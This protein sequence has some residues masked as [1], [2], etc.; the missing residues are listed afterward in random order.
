MSRRPYRLGAW[1]VA[2]VLPLCG[3]ADHPPPPDWQGNAKA[4]IDEATRAVLVGDS[5][6]EA[7]ALT[8]ARAEVARTGQPALAARLELMHCAARVASLDFAP[9]E[10]FN[11][12]RVDAAAPERA[13]A[14]YLA[15]Q[16]LPANALGLLPAAQQSVAAARDDTARLAAAQAIDDPQARLIAVAVAFEA[17]RASPAMMQLAVDTASAQGWRRPLLAWLNVQALRADKAGDADEA[18]RLRRRIA[19]VEGQATKGGRDPGK[20]R[21]DSGDSQHLPEQ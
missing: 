7:S 12:L 2:I 18:Q 21:A 17:T 15:G 6:A 3:C 9:C 8:R 10:G 14:D 4:A 13:Y 19:L 11:A 20:P 16:S 1:A 5:R